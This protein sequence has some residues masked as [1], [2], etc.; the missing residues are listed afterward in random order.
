MHL[1]CMGDRLKALVDWKNLTVKTGMDMNR[2][3]LKKCLYGQQTHGKFFIP[4][5]CDTTEY[6]EKS[7]S[8]G[9]SVMFEAQLGAPKGY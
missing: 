4:F 3:K 9:K 1:Q 6:L 5:I 2:L 8:E 7:I